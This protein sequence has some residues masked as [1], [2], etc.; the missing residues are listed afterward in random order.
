MTHVKLSSFFHILQVYA[1]DYPLFLHR[2]K[3][4]SV[5]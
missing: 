2:W 5:N 1:M 3:F 4:N